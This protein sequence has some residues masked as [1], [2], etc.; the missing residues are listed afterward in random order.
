MRVTEP[1]LQHPRAQGLNQSSHSNSGLS[2]SKH[3]R[4]ESWLGVV[5]FH[6]TTCITSSPQT[7]SRI[8]AL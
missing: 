7:D 1:V 3:V 4:Q 5:P 6:N 8:I 2:H